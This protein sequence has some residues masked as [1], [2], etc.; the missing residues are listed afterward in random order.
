MLPELVVKI[1]SYL[2]YKD[3]LS[4]AALVCKRWDAYTR[5]PE[6]WRR[7]NLRYKLDTTTETVEKLLKRS[8]GIKYIDLTMCKLIKDSVIFEIANLKM[9]RTLIL[10]R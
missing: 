6:L 10:A 5:V 2:R 3:L 9:L 4:A 1:F 7:I 8:K